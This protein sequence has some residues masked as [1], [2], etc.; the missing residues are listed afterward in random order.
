MDST[1]LLGN[2]A[3][4]E[5]DIWQFVCEVRTKWLVLSAVGFGLLLGFKFQLLPWTRGDGGR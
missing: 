3:L 4:P 2:I 5:K 1:T